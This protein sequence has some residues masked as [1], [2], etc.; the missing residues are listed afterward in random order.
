MRTYHFFKWR[1]RPPPALLREA[2]PAAAAYV[3]GA[4]PPMLLPTSVVQSIRR[5]AD[6]AGTKKGAAYDD[7]DDDDDDGPVDKTLQWFVPPAAAAHDHD[8]NHDGTGAAAVLDVVRSEVAQTLGVAL[9][10]VARGLRSDPYPVRPPLP[11]QCRTKS[12]VEVV[13]A[14]GDGSLLMQVRAA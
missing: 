2:G 4:R 9:H 3:M 13:V 12:E 1:M 11:D 10:V 5:L 6:G 7:D 14:R 8:H